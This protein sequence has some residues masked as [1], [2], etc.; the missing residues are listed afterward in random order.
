MSW[1]KGLVLA[2]LLGTTLLWTGTVQAG[3]LYHPVPF[4]YNDNNQWR[5]VNYPQG[6]VTLGGIPFNIPVYPPNNNDWDSNFGGGSGTRTLTI[7]VNLYNVKEVHTV[8]GVSYG[9]DGLQLTSLQ[10]NWSGGLTFTKVLTDGVDI[11]DWWAGSGPQTISPPTVQVYAGIGTPPPYLATRLDKQV[12]FFNEAP[13]NNRT[14]ESIVITDNG[15]DG[16]HR[17]FIYGLTAGTASPNLG[18]LSLLLFGD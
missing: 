4:A 3:L 2:L 13:Y 12:F 11:R 8:M 7:P 10:F 6:S 15:A 18:G 16:V 9:S 1:F 14:L 5:D 17:A